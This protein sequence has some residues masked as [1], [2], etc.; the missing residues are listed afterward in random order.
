MTPVMTSHMM[1][2]DVNLG[3]ENFTLIGARSHRHWLHSGDGG[4]GARHAHNPSG[5]VHSSVRHCLR[6]GERRAGAA[7]DVARGAA[8]LDV[9]DTVE[10]EIDGEVDEHQTIA[11]HLCRLVGVKPLRILPHHVM[12]EEIQQSRRSC[13]FSPVPFFQKS[14]CI[15]PSIRRLPCCSKV[16]ET[17]FQS[18]SFLKSGEF[19]C[20]STRPK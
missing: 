15:L 13:T 5:V 9:D 12:L 4:G 10:D 6:A 18:R 8:K 16:F 3:D 19:Y 2:H 20:P 14:S 7:D 17:F 1:S 11:N